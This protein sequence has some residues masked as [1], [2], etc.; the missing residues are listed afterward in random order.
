ME[1]ATEIYYTI[2]TTL[3][4]ARAEVAE[5]IAPE[6]IIGP[7]ALLRLLII[8]GQRGVLYDIPQWTEL[9][10]GTSPTTSIA[11]VKHITEPGLVCKYLGYAMKN[12]TLRRGV[13]RQFSGSDLERARAIYIGAAELAAALISFDIVTHHKMIEHMRGI[14]QEFI[15]CLGNAAEMCIR[16]GEFGKAVSFAKPAL[17]AGENPPE[18]EAIDPN[19]IAKNDRRLEAA[20]SSLK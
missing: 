4:G 13:G 10:S 20:K 2:P 6:S 3:L 17:E 11:Q 16:L 1:R 14:Y 19:L 12:A 15:L 5:H 7:I 18:G 8:L 9:P